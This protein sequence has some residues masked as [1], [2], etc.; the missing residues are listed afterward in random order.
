MPNNNGPLKEA[1]R[2]RFTIPYRVPTFSILSTQLLAYL[3]P[4]K[5]HS[6]S[7]P[8]CSSLWFPHPSSPCPSHHPLRLA[9]PLR[10]RLRA[11]PR[12]ARLSDARLRERPRPRTELL[13]ELERPMAGEAGG[14]RGEL[15]ELG[16]V[17]G[18]SLA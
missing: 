15:G 14:R 12:D 17:D 11:S 9:L 8:P 10:L 18:L 6:S 5:S 1:T 7:Y 16:W 2:C 4:T 3:L 13:S